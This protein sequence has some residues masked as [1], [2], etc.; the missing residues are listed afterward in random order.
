MRALLTSNSRRVFKPALLGAK[1]LRSLLL[2]RCE[3]GFSP[4]WQTFIKHAIQFDTVSDAIAAG[5][6]NSFWY[7]AII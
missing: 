2:S 6:A 3:E 5:M 1:L 7:L 4:R